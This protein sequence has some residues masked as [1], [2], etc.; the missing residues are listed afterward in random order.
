MSGNPK[1]AAS[2]LLGGMITLGILLSSFILGNYL[3]PPQPK[4]TISVQGMAESS[5][6]ATLGVWR[7]GVN[8]VGANYSAATES[9][10]AEMIELTKFLVIQGLKPEN[11]ELKPIYVNENIE[12]YIDDLGKERSRKNGFKASRDLYVTTKE[13]ETLK[14]TFAN[15]QDLK[16]SKMAVSF[17]SPQ[18][19]LENM[20]QIK[21]TL[22]AQA[23]KDALSKAEELA[24]S[25]G[26][27]V[28]KLTHAVPQSFQILSAMPSAETENGQ[29]DTGSIDKKAR[30]IVETSYAIE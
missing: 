26:V 22:I 17:D 18:Y 16:A 4:G 13:L 3:Q 20:E 6:K 14:K 9:N 23:T 12:H 24:K 8:T 25:S 11:F 2:L 19:H 29:N 7:V 30:L 10:K 28:G 5:H 27:S 1:H 21:H 15:I